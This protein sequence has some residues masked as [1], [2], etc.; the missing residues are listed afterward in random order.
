MSPTEMTTAMRENFDYKFQQTFL[1]ESKILKTIPFVTGQETRNLKYYIPVD[2]QQPQYGMSYD[3]AKLETLQYTELENA[4]TALWYDFEIN[5]VHLKILSQTPGMEFAPNVMASAARALDQSIAKTI[6]Q[7]N[8][9]TGMSGLIAKAGNND[10]TAS[11]VNTAPNFCTVMA[12]MKALLFADGFDPPYVLVLSD[13]LQVAWDKTINAAPVSQ[14][15]QGDFIRRIMSTMNDGV[16]GQE[17]GCKIIWEE[18]GASSGNSIKPLPAADA[19]DSVALVMKPVQNG[20]TAFTGVWC[21]PIVST[22]WKFDT[23]SNRWHTRIKCKVGLKVW[24]V[25]SICKHTD[26]DHA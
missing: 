18:N 7:G 1:R 9:L 3:W 15:T 2:L 6:Y 20:Q 11:A 24:D 25:D 26:I 14:Y 10:A 5:D 21:Q 8:T 23:K 16:I 4:P 17:G 13:G 19:D 12:A 22:D